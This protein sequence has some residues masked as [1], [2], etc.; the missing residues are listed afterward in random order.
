MMPSKEEEDL[1]ARINELPGLEGTVAADVVIARGV[2]SW[3]ALG[4]LTPTH[5]K[6]VLSAFA[7]WGLLKQTDRPQDI[8]NK[9][10]LGPGHLHSLDQLY[11]KAKHEIKRMESARRR[12]ALH[13]EG[14]Y[15]S[16]ATASNSDIG[17]ALLPNIAES[18]GNVDDGDYV[19]VCGSAEHLEDDF[20]VVSE[21]RA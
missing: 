4:R 18:H 9:Q 11:E 7:E 10:M 15:T 13:H 16:V 20:C 17:N 3:A 21:P 8:Q 1:R 19:I 6:W 5:Y 2:R 14:S 12:S